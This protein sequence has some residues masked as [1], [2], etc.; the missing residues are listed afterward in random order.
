[1][2]APMTNMPAER[3]AIVEEAPNRSVANFATTANK[4]RKFV[5]TRKFSKVTARNSLVHSFCPVG[6]SVSSLWPA[7]VRFSMGDRLVRFRTLGD[8]IATLGG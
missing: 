7:S 6:L 8:N 2:S 3:P 5:A 1:M 4:M